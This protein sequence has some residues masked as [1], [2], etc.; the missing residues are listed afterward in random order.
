MSVTL[1]LT[2]YSPS[3]VITPDS[4]IKCHLYCF[5][6]RPQQLVFPFLGGGRSTNFLL[7]STVFTFPCA[8]R[9]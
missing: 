8:E 6:S 2:I 3:D 1:P 9:F 5:L 7:K 4:C